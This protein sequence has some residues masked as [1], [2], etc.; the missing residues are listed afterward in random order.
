MQQT[1]DQGPDPIQFFCNEEINFV[2]NTADQRPRT[3]SN[4]VLL[5]WTNQLIPKCCRPKTKDQIQFSSFAMNK[6]TSSQMQQTKDQGPDSIQFLCHEQIDFFPNTADQRPRTRFNS[7]PL[8][9][10]NQLLPKCCR[11]KTKD[12]IKFSSFAMNKLTFPKCSRPKTKDQ[13]LFSSFAMNKSTYSQMQ[14]TKDQGPDSIQFL[15]HDQINFFANVADQRP[16]TRSNSFPLTWTNQLLPK[17]SRPKTKDQI[18]FSSF[19]MNKSTYSQVPQTKDQGPDSIQFIC[20]IYIN[21]FPNAADQRPRT[22]SN[23]VPL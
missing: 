13:I 20:H 8:P 4:S 7:A 12:Q 15:C 17:Y 22:R 9:W 16:R 14:Q 21:F 5:Q 18:Q 3:R 6:L 2:P 11:P 23:S 19:A 1:K 10:T